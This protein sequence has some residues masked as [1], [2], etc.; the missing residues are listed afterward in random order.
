MPNLL[1]NRFAD[2]LDRYRYVSCG[3]STGPCF[4]GWVRVDSRCG[5]R[6]AA[7]GM[8]VPGLSGAGKAILARKA[9]DSNDVLSD[10]LVAVRHLDDGWRVFGAPFWGE[11]A[12]GGISMRSWPLRT[13]AV[14]S[15]SQ[16]GKWR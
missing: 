1:A 7:L 6:H 3:C 8:I 15:H 11:F 4:R 9:P 16:R 5:L 10:E 2:A 12:R 14:L 13:L